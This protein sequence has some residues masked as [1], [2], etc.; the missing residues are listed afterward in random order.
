M[1]EL[2]KDAVTSRWVI[3]STDRRKR[4]YDFRPERPSVV[5]TEFCPFCAGREG[6]TPP[7]VLAFRQNGSVPNSAGWDLRVVPNKFPALQVEG[8]LDREGEGMFDRMNG[9]GAHEVIIETPEHDKTLASLSVA[10][11]ERVLWAFRERVLDLKRDTRFRYILIFKNHGALA[12][13]TLEHSHSQLIA[14]PIVPDF[15]RAELDGARQHFLAKERCVFCDI[16]RQEI[17][18]GRRVILENA[19]IVALA[20]YAARFPFETWLLPRN[21]AARF[22]EAPREVYESL[23]RMLKSMLERMNCALESPAYNLFIH[24]L[25]FVEASGEFYHWHVELVPKVARTAGFESGTG[26]YINPTSPEE[27]AQVLRAAVP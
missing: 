20:P 26:F 12:G 25:P 16:I 21:H 7:E 17:S 14:L 22:E 4:P 9:I 15:V 6:M 19:E 24:N 8:N 1:P 13:A 23:A 27:A 18:A 3:I 11:L 2:R 10:E 5:G